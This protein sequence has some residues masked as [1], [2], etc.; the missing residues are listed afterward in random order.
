MVFV[1]PG[2]ISEAGA[3][4]GSAAVQALVERLFEQYPQTGWGVQP[5]CVPK[6]FDLTANNVIRHRRRQSAN[7]AGGEGRDEGVGISTIRRAGVVSIEYVIFDL[8]DGFRRSRGASSP[9]RR[10]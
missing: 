5:I 7:R 9:G 4:R 3:H 8:G 1:Y 6:L 10:A 2:D